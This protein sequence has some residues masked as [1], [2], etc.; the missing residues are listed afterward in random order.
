[1]IR[2]DADLLKVPGS[3]AQSARIAQSGTEENVMNV[4]RRYRALLLTGGLVLILLVAGSSLLATGEQT[5]VTNQNPL[6]SAIPRGPDWPNT[7]LIF[8]PQ[9]CT[10]YGDPFS[11]WNSAFHPGPYTYEYLIRIPPE[12]DHDVVRV[13]LFDPDSINTAVNSAIVYFS[14]TAIDHDPVRFPPGGIAMTCFWSNQTETCVIETGEMEVLAENPAVT[15]E[16]INPLWFVRL[17][18]NRGAGP[19][20]GNGLC[21]T[22]FVY[23]PRYNTQ[24]YY[25]LFYYAESDAGLPQ[26]VKLAAYTGQVGDEIRDDGDHQT[27][28]RWVSP[29]GQL[30][31]GQPVPVPADY[32]SFEVDL[33]ADTPGLIVDPD[34][35]NRYL[36]LGVT[37]L[38]GASGQGFELWAGPPHLTLSG[39]GNLRRLQLVNEPTLDYSA[40]VEIVALDYA[41]R[42]TMYS[43]PSIQPLL[44]VGPEYAG[45]TIT[46]T[47]FDVDAGSQPPIVFSFDTL[48]Y[49]PDD[50][51]VDRIDHDLTD[52]ALS[53]G[54][55]TDPNPEGRCFHVDVPGNNRCTNQWIDPPYTITIPGD[56]DCD[57]QNPTAASCTPFSGGYLQAR[58]AAGY[59]DSAAWSVS[60]PTSSSHDPTIGCS[61]FPIAPQFLMRSATPPG[62]GDNPYPNPSEFTYPL[63]PPTY[64]QFLYH[65]PD[66]TLT[67]APP[68]TVYRA[69][70]DVDNTHFLRWNTGIA[71]SAQTLA[72]SL[73]WPSNT[74]DYTDHGDAGDPA[75]PLF[76]YVVR[77]YVNPLDKMDTS[78]GLMQGIPVVT[79]NVN[80]SVVRD[81]LNSHIDRS[82]LLRLPVWDEM[83]SSG[84]ESRVRTRRF[85]LFRLHGYNL[86]LSE[87]WLL[88]EFAGWDDSCGQS[89][90]DP[91]PIPTIGPTATF[92]PTPDPVITL[93]PTSTGEPTATS[94]S[95][96]TATNTATSTP[97]ATA[98]A[99]NTATPTATATN[100]PTSTPTA[101]AT[102]VPPPTYHF[103]LPLIVQQ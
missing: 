18:Q 1:M 99:T 51:A 92:T 11:P 20:H 94:T 61:A 43:H 45:Q 89:P 60:G 37:S 19:E 49:Q 6:T 50:T 7:S 91:P 64:G 41:L 38:S 30:L 75:T 53:F 95:T 14:Q 15:T 54:S 34:N 96:A 46:V 98:T 2:I 40:G 21:A 58:Y 36:Y 102:A 44:Y 65:Q 12:Y 83:E 10:S 59:I 23:T 78:L 90:S 22:P 80:A 35:G 8:G 3:L 85:G 55:P 68:G 28:M 52:W 13:E 72:N 56:A 29:G 103:Y 101:T 57:Y 39:D 69:W 27:D 25:E 81:A 100:T 26:R 88:L 67:D 82:R 87:P 70:L 33:T 32:G 73:S 42:R 62:S 31:P 77:G 76:P 17:D 63:N 66:V 97:T 86:S 74:R 79:G 24:T 48:A 9:I 71:D 16:Q 5:A 47:L 4:N 84:S 93:T